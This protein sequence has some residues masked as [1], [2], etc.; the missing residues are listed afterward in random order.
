MR[1]PGRREDL[2]RDRDSGPTTLAVDPVAVHPSRVIR[3]M[4]GPLVLAF[5]VAPVCAAFAQ[6]AMRGLDLASP[7]MTTAEMTR[8]QVEAVLKAVPGGRGADFSGKR[9]SGLDLSGL[10]LS[11]ANFHAARL[12]HTNL[13]HANLDRA[14]LD[15]A[16]ALGA[17]LTGASLVKASLFATQ[18]EGARLDG[19][20]LTGARVT[21]DLTGAHLVG[22]RLEDADCGADEKNQSMGLM[23]A[24]SNPRILPAR[25]SRR[26]ILHARICGSPSLRTPISRGRAYATPTPAVRICAAPFFTAPTCRAWTSILLASTRQAF[27]LSPRRSTLIALSAS[28]PIASLRR[29]GRR[30]KRAEAESLPCRARRDRPQDA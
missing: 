10:D 3:L 1:L 6:N 12:N 26:P 5:A 15:Q 23:R 19:A 27:P 16:W 8:G 22:A 28:D 25:I 20:N 2:T 30:V 7:D 17:D 4:A 13:S 9:L 18:M 21:A 14:T 29:R 11:G 24:R